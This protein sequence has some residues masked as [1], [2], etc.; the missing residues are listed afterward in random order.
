MAKTIKKFNT[1]PKT[2]S[3]K[4]I[5]KENKISRLLN[6]LDIEK[7]VLLMEEI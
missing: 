3:K 6:K 5:R 4:K 1:I 7:L 2:V